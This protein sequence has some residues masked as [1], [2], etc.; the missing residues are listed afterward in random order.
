MSESLPDFTFLGKKIMELNTA[1]FKPETHEVLLP[2]N[3]ITTL[4]VDK[5]GHIW[6]FTSCQKTVTPDYEEGFYCSLDY[7]N[8]ESNARINVSGSARLVREDD[9]A[10]MQYADG[11]MAP[12]IAERQV[13]LVDLAIQKADCYNL[14][15]DDSWLEKMKAGFQNWLYA[16]NAEKKKFT[17]NLEK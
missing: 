17:I 11:F 1:L 8:K 16:N 15:S 6:F 4:D 13:L 14:G 10:A 12:S 5:N 7:F 2:N 9:A 3:I